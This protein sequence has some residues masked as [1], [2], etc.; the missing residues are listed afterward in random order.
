MNNIASRTTAEQIVKFYKTDLTGKVA[1]VTGS[2]SGTGL[3]TARVLS[4][5][6]AK[7]I[8]PCRTIEKSNGAIKH[9]KK[10]VPEADLVPMQL[11]LSDLLSIKKFATDFLALDIPLHLLINNAGIMACPKAF[12]KDGFES[13]FGVNHLGH[14]YLTNL[15]LDKLKASTPSRIINLT[16][17]GSYF[18]ENEKGIDFDNLYGEQHYS[19]FLVYGQ[20]KLANILHA[21]ELQRRFDEERVDVVVT[22]VHPGAVSTNLGRSLGLSAAF[23]MAWNVKKEM[24]FFTDII[25]Y[26]QVDEGAS[27]TVYC[28]VS[29]DVVK[30]EFYADNTIETKLRSH[31]IDNKALAE[32]LWKVSEEMIASKIN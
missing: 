3:E 8:I 7:V 27:T 23:D 2:N 15:L 13:Q 21:K 5:V 25:H 10:T 22:S 6:G 16:S 32:K 19:P 28:A 17:S 14:F 1:I 24:C 26:K 18:F 11:D 30:G 4:M 20:S 12:T 29:P 31:H 9:I